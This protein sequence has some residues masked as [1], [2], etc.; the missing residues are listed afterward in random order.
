M[1]GLREKDSNL[2]AGGLEYLGDFVSKKEKKGG[3]E[4]KREGG[5][6]R[7]EGAR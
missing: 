1:G 3:E 6:K 4:V 5:R 2:T 7:G